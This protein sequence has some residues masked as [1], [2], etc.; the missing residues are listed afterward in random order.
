MKYRFLGNS[1]ISVS[2]ICIGALHFGVYLSKEES[3]RLLNFGFE[4]GL[5]FIDT[6]PLYG[7]GLSEGYVGEFIAKRRDRVVVS[8]KAGLS[9][10]E[11][12]DGSFGVVV[13]KLNSEGIRLNLEKSLKALNTE[14]IDIYQF[15]AYD[16]STPI[17]ESLEVIYKLIDEGKIKA[18]GA[19]NYSP[20]ELRTVID[21]F[22]ESYKDFFVALESHVNI[23]ERRVEEELLPLC[24]ENN[25]SILPYRALARG[26]LSGKYSSQN[27]FP[28][29][30]RA[31]DSWR[32]R[33]SIDSDSLKLLNILSKFGE[34][35]KIKTLDVAIAWLLRN[36]A[37]GSLVIG[38]R[39]ENQLSEC[40]QA[41][42]VV[43]SADDF[44][45][46]DA[47]LLD[48]GLMDRINS[49]PAVYFEQ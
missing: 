29:G 1:K 32:V 22:D 11:R 40:I 6:G 27:E 2:E 30:S 49:S 25:I 9:R 12:P 21:C 41:T 15:H 8:T 24:K 28:V 45:E 37:I 20:E 36:R 31:N 7:N 14:Y 48:A 3:L 38:A 10:I 35:R 43:L 16:H 46:L 33:N 39:D 34:Q 42:K 18:F 26:V 44:M 23:I 19:S 13:Q 17:D 4:A 47:L 5:N